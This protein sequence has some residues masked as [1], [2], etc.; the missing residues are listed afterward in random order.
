MPP[1][2]RVWAQATISRRRSS[3]KRV[4]V[5]K[6]F[7]GELAAVTGGMNVKK[8]IATAALLVLAACGG[9]SSTPQQSNQVQHASGPDWVN[10]GSGA[11][12]GDK[13][14]T[15]YGVGIASGIHNAAMRRSDR[16]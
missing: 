10:R 14:R 9:G 8:L 11:F 6:P 2:K 5:S 7:R 1:A 15:F 13:G 3:R 12:G 4:R 16:K